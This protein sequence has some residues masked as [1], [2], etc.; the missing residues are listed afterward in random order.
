MDEMDPGLSASG[1]VPR[2]GFSWSRASF[3]FPPVAPV[4]S[5]ALEPTLPYGTASTWP[6]RRLLRSPESFFC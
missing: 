5:V 6:P 4:V 2:F 3:P 1:T